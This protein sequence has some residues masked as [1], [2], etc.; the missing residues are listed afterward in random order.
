MEKERNKKEQESK[1]CDKGT[2]NIGIG[3]EGTESACD[4]SDPAAGLTNAHL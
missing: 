4:Y 3:D 1:T 2:Q